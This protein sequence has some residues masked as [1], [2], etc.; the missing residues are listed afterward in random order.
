MNPAWPGKHQDALSRNCFDTE[1]STFLQYL[2][3]F[4]SLL[5]PQIVKAC[6]SSAADRKDR[7]GRRNDNQRGVHRL[8]KIRIVR[9]ALHTLDCRSIGMDRIDSIPFGDK[10]LISEV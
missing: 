9:I 6:G 2:G 3:R 8:W 5:Q 7:L 4:G 10:R 1:V